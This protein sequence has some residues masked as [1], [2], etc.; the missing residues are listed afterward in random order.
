MLLEN[1]GQDKTGGAGP[2][3]RGG[4]PRPEHAETRGVCDGRKP[5]R[6]LCLCAGSAPTSKCEA[7]EEALGAQGREASACTTWDG[8]SQSPEWAS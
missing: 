3:G 7:S 5:G 2:Q 8:C 4:R 1:R 6:L